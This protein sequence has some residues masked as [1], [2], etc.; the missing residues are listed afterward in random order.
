M[1]AEAIEVNL[2][3]IA[4]HQIKLLVAVPFEAWN[5]TVAERILPRGALSK[6]V[7]IE[8]L[9]AYVVQPEVVLAKAPMK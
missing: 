2:V 3:P 5:R 9:V 6:A 7:L 4:V 8:V 1:E